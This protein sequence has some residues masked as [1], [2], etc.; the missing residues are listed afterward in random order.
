[1]TCS[2]DCDKTVTLVSTGELGATLMVT[3]CEQTPLAAQ[4]LS[5]RQVP[6]LRLDM[7]TPVAAGASLHDLVAAAGW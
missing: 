7:G 3:V 2:A 1:M 5:R 6:K 4:R